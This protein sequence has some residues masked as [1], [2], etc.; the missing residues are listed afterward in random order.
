M[1]IYKNIV[2]AYQKSSLEPSSTADVKIFKARGL[3]QNKKSL[4]KTKSL[5]TQNTSV[6]PS[7]TNDNEIFRAH[8]L[9]QN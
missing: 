9:L 8:W 1:F 3:L 5:K 6:E 7:S 2:A 4:T